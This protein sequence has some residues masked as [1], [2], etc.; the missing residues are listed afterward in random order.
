MRVQAAD[1]G[2][3][4]A[5]IGSAPGPPPLDGKKVRDFNDVMDPRALQVVLD[6]TDLDFTAVMFGILKVGPPLQQQ[7]EV[8]DHFDPKFTESRR[9][10]TA[11]T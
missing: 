9:Q 6:E 4:I 7:G 3:V 5:L 2:G 1:V 10:V 11:C 8:Y